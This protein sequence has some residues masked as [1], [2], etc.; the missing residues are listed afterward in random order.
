MSDALSPATETVV[1]CHACEFEFTRALPGV[2]TC[3]RC[4]AIGG[5]ERIERVR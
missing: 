1:R 5:H 3:P 4:Q 2:A